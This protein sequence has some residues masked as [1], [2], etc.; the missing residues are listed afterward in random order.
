MRCAMQLEKILVAAALALLCGCS[1]FNY[2]WRKAAA[3]P[4]SPDTITG[5]WD[6]R[7]LSH[8]NG[9]NDRLRC[10]IS[11]TGSNRYDAKFHA[12]YSHPRFTWFKVHF[13]YTV[14]LQTLPSTNGVTFRGQEN[15]GALAGGV[16]T[17]E[18]RVTATNFFSTYRSKYDHGIFEMKRP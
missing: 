17:Y 18:G 16:Y 10:L 13:G 2:E 14:P 11:Q 8:A 3:K 9:H 5:R 6:G 7:W 12:A 4:T 15:L 1:T